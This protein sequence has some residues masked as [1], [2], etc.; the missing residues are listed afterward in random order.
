MTDQP[1]LFLELT[2]SICA[3]CHR[4]VEAKIIERDQRIFMQKRCPEHG[5]EKVLLSTD[6]AYYRL[7]R[8]TLKPGKCRCTLQRASSTAVPTIVDC[9]P[10]TSNIRAS[11]SS[12]S[13]TVVI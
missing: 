4:K 10:T 6:P 1:Y 2:T 5:F 8:E 13:R 9:A 3:T 12:R 11:P 7:C